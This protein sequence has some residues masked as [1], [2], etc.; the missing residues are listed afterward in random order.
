MLCCFPS[1]VTSSSCSLFLL[2]YSSVAA[3]CQPTMTVPTLQQSLTKAE[4]AWKKSQYD[5]AAGI[6][7]QL[8]DTT[9][10]SLPADE[11]RVVSYYSTRR[12]LTPPG[13]SGDEAGKVRETAIL[14]LGEAY[15]K[16]Q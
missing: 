10:G 7:R 9:Q 4:E 16:L 15:K 8:L 13:K 5:E 14:K 12:P 11:H 6:Y 2:I 3:L 1:C